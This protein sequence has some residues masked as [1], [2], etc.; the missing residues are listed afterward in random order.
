MDRQQAIKERTLEEALFITKNKATIRQ[1]AA[2]SDVSKSTTHTDLTVRLPNYSPLLAKKVRKILN[3]NY[4][5]RHIRGGM[6]TRE[7]FIVGKY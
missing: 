3:K 7:K 6:A 2:N 4:S 5:E 1:T